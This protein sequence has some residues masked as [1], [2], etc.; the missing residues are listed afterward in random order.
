[1][2]DI[3][4]CASCKRMFPDTVGTRVCPDGHENPWADDDDDYGDE[5]LKRVTI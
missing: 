1:M 3:V 5:Y 2:N 4:E